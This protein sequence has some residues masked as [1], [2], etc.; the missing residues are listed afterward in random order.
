MSLI[1]RAAVLV[2]ANALDRSGDRDVRVALAA[3][4]YA[5]GHVQPAGYDIDAAP[6]NAEETLACG[7]GLCGQISQISVDIVRRLGLSARQIGFRFT[8]ERGEETHVGCEFWLNDSWRFVDAYNL[9]FWPDQDGVPLDL[10]TVR[11]LKAPA[12]HAV[13]DRYSLWLA[14]EPGVD[15]FAYLA[16]PERWVLT[17][18][19]RGAEGET[20]TVPA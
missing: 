13:S 17:R 19:D 6:H 20:I 12:R 11:K 9:S 7:T 5:H 18:D 1:H 10:D 2:L 4:Q 15:P 8:T 3:C 16:A 14:D